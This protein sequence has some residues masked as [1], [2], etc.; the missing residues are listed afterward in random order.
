MTNFLEGWTDERSDAPLH[1]AAL[2][3][4]LAIGIGDEGQ[5]GEMPCAFHGGG[6]SALVSGARARLATRANLST[7]GH[8][9]L[10]HVDVLV[11]NLRVLVG[12]ED[13]VAAHRL[14]A[15]PPAAFFAPVI[16]SVSFV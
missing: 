8:E 1:P 9:P 12:A 5:Q 6:N 10:E 4:R 2:P 11:V 3:L 16:P 7:V 15:L 13:A 14:V